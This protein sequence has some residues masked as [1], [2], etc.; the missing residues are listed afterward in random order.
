MMVVDEKVVIIA[1]YY[2][3]RNM[4]FGSITNNKLMIS[5]VAEH[6][7]NDIYL[8]NLR[9]KYGKEIYDNEVFIN[10][11]FENRMRGK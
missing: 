11:D 9:N 8:L 6:I 3:D 4:W 7:H 5:I 10:S 2:K 1:D